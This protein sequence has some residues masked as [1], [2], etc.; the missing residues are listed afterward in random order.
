M[1]SVLNLK[2]LVYYPIRSVTKSANN[3]RSNQTLSS[4]VLTD[5][6]I[7]NKSPN[8]Q[9]TKREQFLTSQEGTGKMF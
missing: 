5:S 7:Y 6:S 2:T 3:P 1:V 9:L 4:Q 8:Q